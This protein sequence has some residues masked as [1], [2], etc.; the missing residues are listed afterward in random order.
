[1]LRKNDPYQISIKC[2][3]TI[4]QGI[5]LTFLM[6]V[7]TDPMNFKSLLEMVSIGHYLHSAQL[8]R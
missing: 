1:M 3:L 6:G 7:K 2:G 5:S 4:L 8:A